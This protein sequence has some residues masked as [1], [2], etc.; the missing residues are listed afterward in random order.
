MIILENSN[1]IN[2]IVGNDSMETILTLKDI[3]SD[4]Y[5]SDNVLFCDPHGNKMKKYE[6]EDSIR[7]ED[8]KIVGNLIDGPLYQKDKY[9]IAYDPVANLKVKEF[10][11]FIHNVVLSNGIKF[12]IGA[13]DLELVPY[14]G[15]FDVCAKFNKEH[16]ITTFYQKGDDE[17]LIKSYEEMQSII[18]QFKTPDTELYA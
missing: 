4:L 18:Q 7:N 14:I 11:N 12:F 17:F 3:Y 15:L 6:S 5:Q 8:L 16:T 1:N 10:K 13:V 2:L 9:F